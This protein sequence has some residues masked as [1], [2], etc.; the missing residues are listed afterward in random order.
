MK[1]LKLI[2][3]AMIMGLIYALVVCVM[4]V[5]WDYRHGIT[6]TTAPT[7]AQDI[8]YCL[9]GWWWFSLGYVIASNKS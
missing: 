3:K 8:V 4:I 9:V 2:A 5:A 6:E 1:R 7:A